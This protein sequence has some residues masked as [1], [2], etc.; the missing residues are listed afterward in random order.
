MGWSSLPRFLLMTRNVKS[1]EWSAVAAPRTRRRKL[2]TWTRPPRRLAVPPSAQGWRNPSRSPLQRRK[3]RSV[4]FLGIDLDG[5]RLCWCQPLAPSSWRPSERSS[6]DTHSPPYA[7]RLC[8]RN[9]RL[10]CHRRVRSRRADC[11]P[12]RQPPTIGRAGHRA[13]R[14][15]RRWERSRSLDR[16]VRAEPWRGR[17]SDLHRRLQE[18]RLH[19]GG[20]FA[21]LQ[22]GRRR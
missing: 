11:K 8:P 1:G 6:N 10:R 13:R 7:H 20:R 3:T 12:A 21:E 4:N 16:P 17:P 15:Q 2:G 18:R 14:A 5:W 9:R 22:P 19:T